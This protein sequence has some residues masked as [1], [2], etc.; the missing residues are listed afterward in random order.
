M[1]QTLFVLL[2]FGSISLTVKAQKD[3]AQP[4]PVL[5]SSLRL[6]LA[7]GTGEDSIDLLL[8]GGDAKLLKGWGARIVRQ[9]TPANSYHIRLKAS[10]VAGLA[11]ARVFRLADLYTPPKEELTTGSLD[12]ATNKAAFSHR[13]YPTLRGDS[14]LASVKENLFD[15]ADI[16][17]ADRWRRTAE[18]SVLVTA[19]ATIMATTIAG[20]ANSSPYAQGVADRSRVTSANFESLLPEPDELFRGHGITVQNH[21]YGTAIQNYYG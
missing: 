5:S 3:T 9:Y 16:D 8:S 18:P 15:T 4:A 2:F 17:Y 6:R 19:H 21:S 20:A 11:E 14:L 13:R 7:Q 12:I 1:R 10:R